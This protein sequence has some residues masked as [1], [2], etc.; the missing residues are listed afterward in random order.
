MYGF[1]LHQEDCV[2]LFYSNRKL[3][4]DISKRKEKFCEKI[5]ITLHLQLSEYLK[6][7]WIL[8]SPLYSIS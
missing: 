5:G 8:L 3:I 2:D 6:D 4:Q 1:S 7:S